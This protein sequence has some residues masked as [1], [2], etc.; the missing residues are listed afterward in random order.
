MCRLECK[1]RHIAFKLGPRVNPSGVLPDGR[2]FAGVA[3]LQ[4]LLAADPDAL[5]DNLARQFAVYATGRPVG[6][7]DRDAIA[8]VVADAK[9]QGGGVRTLLLAVVQSELF[10]TK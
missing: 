2:K 7:G 6:F 3:E 8:A 4:A 9:R 5:S 10:R 1:V